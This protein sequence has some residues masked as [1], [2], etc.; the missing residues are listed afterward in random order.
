MQLR[1]KGLVGK[2]SKDD[3]KVVKQEFKL[4]Q[5][6][7]PNVKELNDL[8]M[9]TKLFVALFCKGKMY[10]LGYAFLG[11]YRRDDKG[12]YY[13]TVKST[14]KAFLPPPDELYEQ[15][16]KVLLVEPADLEAEMEEMKQ[17]T[18]QEDDGLEEE[19]IDEQATPV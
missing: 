19:V 13:I 12:G 6:E 1:F 10:Q 17:L 4:P 9:D 3:Q 8:N 7:G 14:S 5:S 18:E 11:P 16:V 2:F 15:E